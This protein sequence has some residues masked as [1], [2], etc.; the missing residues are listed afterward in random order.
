MADSFCDSMPGDDQ[1]RAAE[2]RECSFCRGSMKFAV[3][4][5]PAGQ[6][7]P[8]HRVYRCEACSRVETVWEPLKPKQA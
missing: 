5:P 3:S 7:S 4:I 6:K 8:G 1:Q 2:P